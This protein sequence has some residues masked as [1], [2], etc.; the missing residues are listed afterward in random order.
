M[1]LVTRTGQVSFAP[2]GDK[3]DKGARMRM[4]VWGASV[5]YLEGKQ[6]QQ[7]Y[8]IVLYDN[9][10][11]LCIRSHTSV[12]TET[13]KQNVASGKIKYWEVAQSWTFIAT[14]LLLTEK[15]KASMIDADGI[16]AVNVDISG[17][18]TA[19]SGRIG[20]FSIDSGMLSSKTLYEGTDSHVGFNL[21]AGQIE[22]YNERTF[23]RVK[24]G[25][26][27]KFV[28]IEGISYDAGIDIQSPNAMIGMHIKT[29]SIP[30]FVEGGNIFLHPNNDS[31]VSLHGIV[32]N[33]RNISVSTS[34]NNN[35]D[36]VMFI[37]TGNIEV[38]LPPDVPG[39]TIY[40]KRM[41]GGVRLTGGRILPAP[42]GKEMSSIDLD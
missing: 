33:W 7:F 17:K 15:I 22:F 13:P 30:L 25:G 16:R 3:G 11:Y 37:N 8:D 26:N 40:F 35:D 6:G 9:L 18:I 32:G 19:D 27:T 10:L 23:A 29:L 21:S 1:P 12:S 36:N 4:R 34:L 38:T 41:S 42:G 20:P 24:I 14:K 5:S 39:H 2:K 31:Y 28:T